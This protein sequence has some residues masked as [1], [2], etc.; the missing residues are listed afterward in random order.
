MILE[1]MV[2]HDDLKD[3]FQKIIYKPKDANLIETFGLASPA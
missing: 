3:V 1:K 2:T